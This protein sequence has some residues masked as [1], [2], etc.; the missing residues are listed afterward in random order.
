MREA[1]RGLDGFSALAPVFFQIA[2]DLDA[3]SLPSTPADSVRE[4]SSVF[5]V[6]ADSA[7]PTAYRG[8]VP[9]QLDWQP[10]LGQLAVRPHDGYPLVSGR[11]YAAV[12]TTRVRDAEGIAI[13]PDPRFVAIRDA[14]TRPADP[15]EA[16]A[17]D[18]YTPVLASLA[19]NGTPREE[20]VA[21]A[22]FTVQDVATDV[23]DARTIVWEGDA[24]VPSLDAVIAAGPELDALLGVP[25]RAGSGVD[26]PGGVAHGNLGWVVQGHFESPNFLSETP[27]VHGPFERDAEG[28][29]V[30]KRADSV[31]FTL[32]IPAGGGENVPLVVFQ[33]GLGGERSDMFALA[34]ALAAAGWATLSIDI[35]FHGMRA[36]MP[37]VD[38]SHRFGSTEGS[39]GFGD[40]TGMQVYV[41][42]LGVFDDRGELPSFHPLYVRDV[43]RQ[44]VVDLFGAVRLAR[45]GDWS[46]LR[47]AGPSAFAVSDSP[48][49][50]VGVSLGG[51]V[52]TVFVAT[53]PE[54]GVA[55]LE[56]TGGD[57]SRLVEGS[58]AFADTF[59][60]LLLPR[61]GVDPFAIEPAVYPASFHPELALYQT[62]LDGG[63]S[64]AYAS[65]LADRSVDV[66]FQM[67]ADD[68][69][70][71][72]RSTEGLA[73]AARAQ[74]LGADPRYTEIERVEGSV[75]DNAEVS[76]GRVT[77]ALTRFEP[78]T[79]GLVYR[80]SD[81]HSFAHPPE[82]PFEPAGPTPVT[83]P[84]DEA[85]AQILFFFESHR[86][87]GAAVVRPIP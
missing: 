21:L 67:A 14:S 7:S 33:H 44:S 36:P 4:D 65:I 9:V 37:E 63:D 45:E 8:R 49:A 52:G 59:M 78:A 30:V 25:E 73:R 66:L 54:V 80:R 38:R 12:V 79:H 31:P 69:V 68:E 17:W 18:H 27:S 75:S 86:S 24:P 23:R 20:V 77:R 53:E 48:I 16:E 58:A 71:P 64:M 35:P 28:R 42:Y 19:S 81:E 74:I 87:G 76:G 56:V 60:P 29:L 40:L 22:V 26:V 47:S 5:L 11:R 55:A 51:I 13:G 57:L 6:D 72:N 3:T 85:I 1:F 82:P 41:E 34:D 43:L 84:V 46:A 15:L 70:V 50:F 32:A 61:L 2:G 39:D 10:T 83:N 62:V